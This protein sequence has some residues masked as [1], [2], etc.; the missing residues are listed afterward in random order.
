MGCILCGGSPSVRTEQVHVTEDTKAKLLSHT[1]ELKS[2]GIVVEQ[3]ATFRKVFGASETRGVALLFQDPIDSGVLRKLLIYLLS[4]DIPEEQILLLRLGEPE[5]ISR[6]LETKRREVKSMTTSALP[7]APSDHKDLQLSLFTELSAAL[8]ARSEPEHL[9]TAA[10]LGGFGAVAWGVAALQPEKYSSK[11]MYQR[12]AGVAALG[13]LLVATAIVMKICRE[14]KKFAEIKK[15]Q[16]RIAAQIASLPGA[17]EIIPKSMLSPI[18]G[19]GYIWSLVVVIAAAG[20]AILFCL[21][22]IGP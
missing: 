9:Y 7:A 17:A 16:A 4:L 3:K 10:A 11:A 2:F 14:H 1:E 6:I 22:L 5:Q 21:S 12:P 20:A 8:R 18:A 13:T 19:K 15:E